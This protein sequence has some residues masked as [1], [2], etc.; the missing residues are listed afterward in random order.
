MALNEKKTS[1][2]HDVHELGL[3]LFISLCF[4]VSSTHVRACDRL[5]GLV[6]IAL[7]G[8]R[9]GLIFDFYCDAPENRSSPFVTCS[10]EPPVFE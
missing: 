10:H 7:A 1:I 3:R 9:V 5:W 4:S 2:C 8:A 6:F